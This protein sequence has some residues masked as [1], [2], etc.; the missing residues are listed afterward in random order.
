[1]DLLLTAPGAPTSGMIDLGNQI[2]QRLQ[3]ETRSVGGILQEECGYLPLGSHEF[4]FLPLSIF[5]TVD[6]GNAL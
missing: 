5:L 6:T 3:H 4:G 2:E 1:M